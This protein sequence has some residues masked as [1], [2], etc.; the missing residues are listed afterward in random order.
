ML[1]YSSHYT[2]SVSSAKF[3][4]GK[5]NERFFMDDKW[6]SYCCWFDVAAFYHKR[7]HNSTLR[8]QDDDIS[9]NLTIHAL[10]SY[11]L[12][13][14]TE[15]CVTRIELICLY[16]IRCTKGTITQRLMS[17]SRW[18]I[19]LFYF[20]DNFNF[21]H[22]LNTAYLAHGKFYIVGKIENSTKS[23]IAI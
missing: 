23:E 14:S 3:K 6:C 8:C 16:M 1:S 18:H 20:Y 21:Y 10:N 9:D 12:L 4:N 15:F 11:H 17:I 2:F 13:F 7:P 19:F 5:Y 22:V